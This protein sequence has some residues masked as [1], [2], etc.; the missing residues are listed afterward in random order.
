MTDIVNLNSIKSNSCDCN[1]P[2]TTQCGCSHPQQITPAFDLNDQF[3]KVKN[4]FGEL[5][6]EWQRTEARSNLGITDILGLEQEQ[7]S[8]ESEGVNVWRMDTSKGG[9]K[10]SYYFTVKNG[11]AGQTPK[12]NIGETYILESG[13][14]PTVSAEGDKTNIVL[15]FG[16]PKGA[17][18]QK[19]DSAYQVYCDEIEDVT[20]NE[21]FKRLKG[22]PGEPGESGRDGV[23]IKNIQIR[24]KDSGT[25]AYLDSERY[26]GDRLT[27]RVNLND[28]SHFDFWV[29]LVV[30]TTPVEQPIFL[31]RVESFSSYPTDNQLL[32]KLN[33]LFNETI[34]D[35]RMPRS[36]D[37]LVSVKGWNYN[38]PTIQNI[39]KD[40]VYMAIKSGNVNS[41]WNVIQLT[42]SKGAQGDPGKDGKNG[43][44]GQD[45]DCDNENPGGNSGQ[46]NPNPN[47][48]ID[49]DFLSKISCVGEVNLGIEV[50]TEQTSGNRFVP[51]IEPNIRLRNDSQNDVFISFSTIKI[52][53]IPA[54]VTINNTTVGEFIMSTTIVN[55]NPIE[56]KS[57]TFK[58]IK[59]EVRDDGNQGLNW[60][61]REAQQYFGVSQLDLTSTSAY[62]GEIPEGNAEVVFASDNIELQGVQQNN[63]ST[64]EFNIN[65][66]TFTV[67]KKNN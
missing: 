32:G 12:I 28:G 51:Y 2:K 34:D 47:T 56:L 1:K 17:K 44:D 23:S 14:A 52:T 16:L 38:C 49:D 58:T 31:Y 6:T 7:Q 41:L 63:I 13:Q 55:L 22:D 19:G 39:G 59:F 54:T 26:E 10:R 36:A 40:F 11:A 8:S 46:D 21:W 45:C 60:V 67:T 18:G 57:G 3:F 66:N 30:S 43:Q 61:N 29:P 50:A 35:S 20:V 5:K 37:Y 25:I 15:H 27:W 42:G 4:L 48:P 53:N 24:S 64:Y 65:S 33:T 62:T 9:T